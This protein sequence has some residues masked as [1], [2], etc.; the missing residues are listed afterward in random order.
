MKFKLLPLSAAILLVFQ[1]QS[2]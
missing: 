1:A 2:G